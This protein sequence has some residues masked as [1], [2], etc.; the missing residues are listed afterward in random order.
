MTRR[1]RVPDL[2]SRPGQSYPGV[3]LE[4]PHAALLRLGP[5][6]RPG[7]TLDQVLG[8]RAALLREGLRLLEEHARAQHRE[9]SGQQAGASSVSAQVHFPGRYN[10]NP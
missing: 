6:A 4:A 3:D 8:E 9:V 1:G 7:A 10:W 5:Q 2:L